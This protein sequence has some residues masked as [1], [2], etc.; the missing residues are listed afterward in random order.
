MVVS[1][2]GKE[3]H[4][5]IYTSTKPTAP[6]RSGD[7]NPMS[8]PGSFIL[9]KEPGYEV[10]LL[11]SSPES[12]TRKQKGSGDIRFSSPKFWDFRSSCLQTGV[13]AFIEKDL[14]NQIGK[15]FLICTTEKHALKKLTLITLSRGLLS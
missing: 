1:F 11:F 2:G 14:R 12:S 15:C 4:T 8:Y 5:K 13:V 6:A 7:Q 9:K 10:D 3:S